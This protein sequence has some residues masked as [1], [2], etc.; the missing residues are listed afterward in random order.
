[1]THCNSSTDIS[2]VILAA[3]MGRRFGGDKPLAGIGDSGRPLMYFSVMDAWRMGIRRL[4]LIINP[5]SEKAF[6]RRFLPHLP[7]DLEVELVHQDAGDLPV[8]DRHTPREKPWGTGH[9]LWC[10]RDAVPGPMIVINAD[11]YYGRDAFERLACHFAGNHDWAMASYPLSKTL[12]ASG[13]VNRGLCKVRD[14]YLAGI[15][16][17]HAIRE[18]GGLIV[19]KMGEKTATLVPGIP[20]SMNVWGFTTQVFNHL[21]QGLERFINLHGSDREAEYYLPDMV[22]KAIAESMRIRVY[23]SRDD[24]FGITYREDLARLENLVGA[25]SE[26]DG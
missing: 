16:E 4:V 6:S 21:E 1:M 14:G 22:A 9:A 5:A 15:S 17:C 2:L 8:T 12:S 25:M 3:G 26:K 13:P 19:G 10:A 20:V 7:T 24:W 23:E 18:E 11:D